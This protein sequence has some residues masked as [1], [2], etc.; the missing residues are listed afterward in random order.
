MIILGSDEDDDSYD[1]ISK[2][3]FTH[4]MPKE[5]LTTRPGITLS[6]RFQLYLYCGDDNTVIINIKL[7]TN[8]FSKK[9]L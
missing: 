5:R 3:A 4:A 1:F 9:S 2:M 8:V 7:E 6:P